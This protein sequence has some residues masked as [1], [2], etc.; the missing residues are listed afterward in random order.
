MD[1]DCKLFSAKLGFPQAT[2]DV[3]QL[4]GDEAMI[5]LTAK[6]V[7]FDQLSSHPTVQALWCFGFDRRM[8]E[9]LSGCEQLEALCMEQVR[10]RHLEPLGALGKLDVLGV[11]GATKVGELDW[12]GQV[13]PL[14]Q[15]RLQ[16]LPRVR[17]LEDSQL[18][19]G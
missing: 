3:G 5:R 11:D 1:F 16:D 9:A 17:S 2:E 6:S 10:L 18:K 4:S 8:L 13:R 12:L 14:S 19:A 15:L 7:G